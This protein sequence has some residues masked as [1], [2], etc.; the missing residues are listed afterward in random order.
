VNHQYP[1]QTTSKTPYPFGMCMPGRAFSSG[2]YR[3]GFGNQEMDNEVSGT[4]NTLDFG[5]RIY[6]S[7]LGKFLSV[8][9]LT[10][11]F[12]MLTPYQYASNRPIN[13]IDLDGLEYITYIYLL[14]NKTGATHLKTIDYRNTENFNYRKYSQS[15]GPEGRGVQYL[16]I[17]VDANGNVTNVN[18]EWVQKQGGWG[19]ISRSKF[20]YHG[21]FYGGG[22]IQTVGP[23][24]PRTFSGMNVYKFW[25][26]PIDMVDAMAR[27]HDLEQEEP[28]YISYEEPKYIFSDIRFVKRLKQYREASDEKGYIDPYTGRPASKEAHNA[29]RNGIW[30]FTREIK[31]KMRQMKRKYRKGDITEQEYNYWKDKVDQ[32]WEEDVSLPQPS[33]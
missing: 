6:S 27:E 26:K 12:P 33:N 28:D 21:L 31:Q 9:P 29:A 32:T 16:Y 23:Y 1:I 20:E 24:F 5:E 18:E 19:G 13:G 30:F 14:D 7:R 2:S 15:F 4:G 25:E 17:E 11:K 10:A 8:D 22:A 3:Y